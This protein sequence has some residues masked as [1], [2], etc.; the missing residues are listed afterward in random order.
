M[1]RG[2]KI[3]RSKGKREESGG[4]RDQVE[5]AISGKVIKKISQARFEV[6]TER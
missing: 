2:R 5:D 6:E 1:N 3:E 4:I